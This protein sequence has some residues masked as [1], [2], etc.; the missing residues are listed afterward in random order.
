MTKSRF[1]NISN[2]CIAE[3][4]FEPLGSINFLSDDFILLE[5]SKSDMNLP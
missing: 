1:V 2:Y 3:Y 5:N 4:M